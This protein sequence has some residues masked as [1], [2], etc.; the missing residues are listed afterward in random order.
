MRKTLQL[1]QLPT[2]PTKF[3][4]EDEFTGAVEK[5]ISLAEKDPV[6]GV[7]NRLI[8]RRGTLPRQLSPL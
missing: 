3:P 5:V 2:L 7:I 6:L 1:P 4:L 8:I